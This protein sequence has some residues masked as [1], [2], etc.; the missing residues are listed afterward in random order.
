M[1]LDL[2]SWLYPCKKYSSLHVAVGYTIFCTEWSSTDVIS[3]W[4]CLGDHNVESSEGQLSTLRLDQIDFL[5]R[6]S[7][8]KK[9]FWNAKLIKLLKSWQL[10]TSYLNYMDIMQI[11]SGW[12]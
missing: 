11:A 7:L 5:T 2:W 9:I 12:F 6:L 1:C 3:F 10:M 4:I 8:L